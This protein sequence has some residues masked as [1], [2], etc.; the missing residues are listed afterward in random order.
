LIAKCADRIQDPRHT[1]L[2]GDEFFEQIRVI[3]AAERDILAHRDR[4]FRGKENRGATTSTSTSKGEKTTVVLSTANVYQSSGKSNSPGLAHPGF[5]TD[6]RGNLGFFHASNR[7]K[8]PY[9]PQQGTA[10]TGSGGGASKKIRGR[11]R[12]QEDLTSVKLCPTPPPSIYP[13]WLCDDKDPHLNECARYA[14]T[15][16]NFIDI[17]VE[18]R[19]VYPVFPAGLP[20]AHGL[21]SVWDS[22][23]STEKA[24]V[25]NYYR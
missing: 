1:F 25:R 21:R 4:F 2:P 10:A 6:T 23:A 5:S 9:A 15:A 16:E 22:P 18:Q 3:E 19:D 20:N 12:R 13:C 11:S 17:L 24:G 7:P 8:G 14:R